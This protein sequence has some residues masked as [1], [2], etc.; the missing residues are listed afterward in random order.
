MRFL[1][2]VEIS[3][4]TDAELEK[5]RQE[6]TE[7]VDNCQ[8]ELTAVQE[9]INHRKIVKDLKSKKGVKRNGKSKSAHA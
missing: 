2:W 4:L 1:K 9:E 5:R 8:A 6:V 3:Q 7:D